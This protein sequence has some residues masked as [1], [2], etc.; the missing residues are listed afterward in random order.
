MT[1]RR[2]QL[3]AAAAIVVG[4]LMVWYLVDVLWAQGWSMHIIHLV[5]ILATAQVTVAAGVIVI[6]V[7]KR[8]R[9][10]LEAKNEE[11]QRLA[12]IGEMV[13]GLVHYQKNLLN[14][15]RGGL[16][17][18]DGAMAKGNQKNLRDGW[19]ML[20]NTAQRIERLTLDMLYY[21]KERVPKREPTDLNEVIQEAV[22]LMREAATDQGVELQAELDEGIGKQFLDRTA[23]YRAILNLVSNAI[24]ACEESESGNLV[25]LKSQAR[26]DEVAVTVAD[27][28][29]GMSDEVRSNLFLRFF[30][31]KGGQGTGLG[32]P[33]VKKVIE[34]HGGSLEVESKL[35]E[36]SAFQ[37]RLPNTA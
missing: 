24:D 4:L 31:T 19:R 13:A 29:I 33:V 36:G 35:G 30:S 14:G 25:S 7:V 26:A 23:I 5:A 17:I 10:V 11:L 15:L 21:V 27:N 20:D 3:G 18:T 1:E 6:I 2:V 9:R 16:Y 28:G 22:D 37:V 34:E 32:L 12:A 8:Y